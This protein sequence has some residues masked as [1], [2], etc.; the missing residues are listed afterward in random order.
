MEEATTSKPE[1]R[2]LKPMVKYIMVKIV[3]MSQPL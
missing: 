3:G 2:W 1:N